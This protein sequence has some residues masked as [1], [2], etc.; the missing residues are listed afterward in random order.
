MRIGSLLAL[1]AATT[2]VASAVLDPVGANHTDLAT[3]MRRDDA[4]STLTSTAA[5]ETDMVNLVNNDAVFGEDDSDDV[6]ADSDDIS[7]DRR[8]RRRK[9]QCRSDLDCDRGYLCNSGFC[10]TGCR[11]DAD[12]SRGQRCLGW[13][14]RAPNPPQC[15][16]YK[17]R[18]T[19]D[20]ECCS[21]ICGHGWRGKVCKHNKHI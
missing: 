20:S 15:K 9:G 11:L 8:G 2:Q 7:T 12:C 14:C 13:Q 6:V 1:G 5:V 16:P 19:D 10:S 3:F 21:G 4:V 17:Q 18:C